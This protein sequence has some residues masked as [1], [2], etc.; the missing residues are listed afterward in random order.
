MSATND[1]T[2]VYYTANK[3]PTSFASHTI[4]QLY[5]AMGDLH[6]IWVSQ[7]SFESFGSVELGKTKFI[8]FKGVP[9][10]LNIYRQA[11]IGAK[12]ADTKYIALCEDDVLYSPEHFKHRPQP[13]KF[14]YNMNYWNI[15]TWGEPVFTQKLGGRRNLG[16]LICER[17]LFIEAME[18]RF[19]RWPDESKVS[20]A[21]WA[22]PSKYERNLGVTVR[23]FEAFCTNPPNV[24]FSHQTALS[25][26]GLGSRK[27]LGEIRAVEVPYWGK[28][29][30]IK[31]LYQ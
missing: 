20:L 7:E 15:A 12:A 29:E 3:L 2:V 19:A 8:H 4:N 14:A 21:N 1:L 16:N 13:G 6:I 10:H 28:A 31:E 25:F 22:E 18:E 30:T 9:A 26:G 27:R 17:D 5:E 11:L 24:M 23:E